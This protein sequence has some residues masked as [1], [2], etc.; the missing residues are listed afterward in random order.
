MAQKDDS[1][2]SNLLGGHFFHPVS[3]HLSLVV[4]PDISVATVMNQDL[5]LQFRRQTTSTLCAKLYEFFSYKCQL[6]GRSDYL[7]RR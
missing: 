3:R 7:L 4:N 6:T 1:G 2:S 5:W